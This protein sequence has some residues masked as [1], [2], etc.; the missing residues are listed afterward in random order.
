VE[1]L[2]DHKIHQMDILPEVVVEPMLQDHLI[3]VLLKVAQ[4]EQEKLI[5]LQI[6]Q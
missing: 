2:Q 5:Q 6:L 3:Q 1:T 4:V